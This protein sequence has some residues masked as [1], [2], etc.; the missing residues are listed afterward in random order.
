[1]IVDCAI[2]EDGRRTATTTSVEEALAGARDCGGF[3]WIGLHEPTAE[4]FERV[5]DVF[6]LH[7][8]AVEDD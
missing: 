4:E 6:D 5:A 3:V 7:P 8:L 2:Y 1:M